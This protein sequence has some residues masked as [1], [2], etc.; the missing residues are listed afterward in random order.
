MPTGE[1]PNCSAAVAAPATLFPP[2]HKF[3]PVSIEG[4]VA[5]SQDDAP[6]VTITGVTQDEPV[7]GCPDAAGIG[8]DTVLL[9][10]S[11][12]P[13]GDGRVYHV[14]FAAND[15]AGGVCTGTV[16]VCVPRKARSTCVDEGALYDSTAMTCGLPCADACGVELL[17][18]SLCPNEHVPLP[19]AHDA[20]RAQA[21]LQRAA[22]DSNEA[23]KEAHVAAAAQALNQG[24]RAAMRAEGKKKI[25]S[26]CAASIQAALGDAR[27]VVR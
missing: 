9:R 17:V 22:H 23:R 26:T 16:S 4:L 20:A 14:S 6:L 27:S 3:V 18:G 8:T 1:L 13:K 24:A 25:S 19:I 7:A 5:G 15:N 12:Q 10:A 11:R 2:N 21:L